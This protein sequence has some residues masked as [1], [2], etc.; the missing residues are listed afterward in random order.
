MDRV[1]SSYTSLALSQIELEFL[2]GPTFLDF[3]CQRS[4]KEGRIWSLHQTAKQFSFEIHLQYIF[5]ALLCQSIGVV[6][7]RKNCLPRKASFSCLKKWHDPSTYN[8]E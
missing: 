5:G 6:L 7:I 8:S 2:C 1:R 4:H 3:G